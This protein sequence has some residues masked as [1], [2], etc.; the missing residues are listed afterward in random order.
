MG[1]IRA[2][3]EL[4]PILALKYKKFHQRGVKMIF[5]GQ[6]PDKE[7]FTQ[8]IGTAKN[9]WIWESIYSSRIRVYAPQAE[10]WTQ[11][12]DLK[13]SRSYGKCRDGSKTLNR[14]DIECHPISIEGQ[15]V[16]VDLFQGKAILTAFAPTLQVY[17]FINDRDNW[18]QLL[19]KPLD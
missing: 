9:R 10:P 13:F 17:G 15:K 5:I 16:K 7:K 1:K 3:Q 4:E 12:W 18:T 2:I 14:I 19:V 6:L 11:E 8:I